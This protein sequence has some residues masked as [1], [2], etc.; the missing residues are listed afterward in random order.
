[1]SAP[2]GCQATRRFKA[3]IRRR[4]EAEHAQAGRASA[5]MSDAWLGEIEEAMEA[6]EARPI[7]F[8]VR[9]LALAGA[10][11]QHR[12]FRAAAGRAGAMC[13]RRMSRSGGG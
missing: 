3:R 6:L 13:G 1:M 2:G 5:T 8:R 4:L 12:R 11:R 7:R 9:D 10:F